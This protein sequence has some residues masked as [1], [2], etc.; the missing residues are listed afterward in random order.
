MNWMN[1]LIF[2]AGFAL[3]LIYL[4]LDTLRQIFENVSTPE[5]VGIGVVL[6][7][8]AY[9][10]RKK[11]GAG[12]QRRPRSSSGGARTPIMPHKHI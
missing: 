9:Q 1:R 10:I 6:S 2:K 8:T 4:V 7:V 5:L 12:P 11:S 3:V